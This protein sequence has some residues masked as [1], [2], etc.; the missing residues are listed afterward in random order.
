MFLS[1]VP[2]TTGELLQR[3]HNK[4]DIKELDREILGREIEIDKEIDTR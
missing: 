3:E 4:V 1:T 2:S